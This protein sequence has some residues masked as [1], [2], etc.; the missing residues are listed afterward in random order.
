MITIVARSSTSVNPRFPEARPGCDTFRCNA[1]SDPKAEQFTKG[2][3]QAIYV[4]F[5]GL[6]EDFDRQG[7]PALWTRP[8]ANDCG[9]MKKVW[10]TLRARLG[11]P[12]LAA[13][14]LGAA[15]IG[16]CGNDAPPRRD[17]PPPASTAKAGACADAEGAPRDPIAKAL[18]PARSGAF[19]LDPHGGEKAYGEDA[20]RPFDRACEELLDGEC[21]VYRS[22]GA[23]RTLEARYIDDAGTPATLVV[24]L[25]KFNTAEG[26]FAMFTLR[27][28]GDG[29]PA[30][31]AAPKPIDAPFTA[32]LGVNNAYVVR[33]PYLAEIVFTDESAG[34]A[35]ALQAAADR[36]VAPMAKEIG[37][38]LTGDTSPPPPVAALPAAGRLPLGVR[39]YTTENMLGI[40]GAGPGAIGYYREGDKR[41][42][43]VSLLRP[44][45]D[46][47]KDLLSL[48]ARWPGA[49]REK[50]PYDGFVRVV[51]QPRGELPAEW[52][53]GRARGVVLGVG[54]EVR[55]LRATLTSA[56]RDRVLLSTREKME[57]LK[58]MLEAAQR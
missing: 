3:C 10:T 23:A 37:A 34:S 33:G 15:A 25:T 54:D 27:V 32:A 26:A 29:D 45:A 40:Q 13:A 6:P 58:G 24:L 42:R 36:H 49:T 11:A 53:L 16:G 47:A 57:K 52:V 19:C 17:P 14:G 18:L 35:S 44:D 46:Q 30:G 9:R 43:V 51:L 55:V 2:A 20:D 7:F 4:P 22:F 38:K 21:E 39:Y 12:A 41:W 56:D 28:V 1:R 48:F 8:G 50:A 5:N 31:E